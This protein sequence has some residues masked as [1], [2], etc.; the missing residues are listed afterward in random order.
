METAAKRARAGDPTGDRLSALP[1]ELLHHV[2]SFLPSRRAVQTS[3]LSK[4][5]TGLWRSVRRIDIRFDV[6]S[7]N[8][9]YNSYS[10]EKWEKAEVFINNLFKFHDA[11]T[12][13]AFQIYIGSNHRDLLPTIDRWVCQG[14]KYRPHHVKIDYSSIEGAYR[15]PH[16]GSSTSLVKKL[17]LFGAYLD[18]SFQAQLRSGFPVLEDL[19][20]HDCCTYFDYIQ[21]STLRKFV[22]RDCYRSSK[23][24]VIRAPAL[25]SLRIITVLYDN[26]VALGGPMNYLVN[27]YIFPFDNAHSNLSR[28]SLLGSLFNVTNLELI[29][30]SAQVML[31]KGLDKYPV[32]MNLK[33]LSLNTCLYSKTLGEDGCLHSSLDP[34]EKLKALGRLLHKAPN[35]ERL[36]LESCWRLQESKQKMTATDLSLRYP[37][38]KAFDCPNL[39]LIEIK[40]RDDGTDD[41]HQMFQLVCGLLRNLQNPVV[42]FSRI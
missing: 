42:T 2:L 25:V 10:K 20:L 15:L 1:D 6:D 36:T 8:Y 22:L 13:D 4:R 14:I 39:K 9:V 38:K 30:L 12:L 23:M 29:A 40:Y 17:D 26:G 24:L 21:S 41:E 19:T 5:W 34:N 35:L 31:D 11:P 28:V 3:G 33:T 32:F 27:A 16:L 18:Y 37:D 7:P